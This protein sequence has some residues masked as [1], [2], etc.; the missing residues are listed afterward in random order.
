MTD[1]IEEKKEIFIQK[2]Q[3]YKE[4]YDKKETYIKRIE[5]S[6]QNII[7]LEEERE[8]LKA[9]RPE[10]LAE[11]EDISELT[12]RLKDIEDDIDINKDTISGVET[13]IK[14]I[15]N[16][17]VNARQD[18]N[19]A[20]QEYIKTLLGKVADQYM[21][22]APKLAEL[23][24]DFIVLEDLRDG[25]GYHWVCFT[26]EKIKCLPSFSDKI[27]FYNNYYDIIRSDTARVLKKY[28]VPEYH[29]RKVRLTEYQH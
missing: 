29:V 13:K 27:L 15:H 14:E 10:L 8:E 26:P 1:K 19:E 22:I 12:Q 17:V 24:K 2:I 6:K 25:D 5:D 21:K 18:T 3:E 9:K 7:S 28:N 11:N 16:K 20:Y 4:I 23:I